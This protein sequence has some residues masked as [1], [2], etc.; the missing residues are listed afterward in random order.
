MHQTQRAGDAATKWILGL[1]LA[2]LFTILI[3]VIAVTFGS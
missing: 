3:M 1:L 2:G